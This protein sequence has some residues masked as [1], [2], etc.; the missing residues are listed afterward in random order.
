M[1]FHRDRVTKLKDISMWK[2]SAKK[3]WWVILKESVADD[4]WLFF[5][6]C[7]VKSNMIPDILSSKHLKPQW[8]NQ[9]G[10]SNSN[11]VISVWTTPSKGIILKR[12]NYWNKNRSVINI[13]RCIRFQSLLCKCSFNSSWD[14]ESTEQKEDGE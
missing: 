14:S 3:G 4:L 7:A 13:I 12:L 11:N 9:I 2:Y 1:Y 6:S 5:H 10:V 8:R